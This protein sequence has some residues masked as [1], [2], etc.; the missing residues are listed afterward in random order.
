MGVLDAVV[1]TLR[2]LPHSAARGSARAPFRGRWPWPSPT[3]RRSSGTEGS[4][5]WEQEPYGDSHVDQG[6]EAKLGE[7]AGNRDQREQVAAAHG[8]GEA[9]K[10]D[11]AEH[12]DLHDAGDD[13]KLLGGDGEDEVGVSIGQRVLDHFLAGTATEQPAD[14]E[15]TERGVDLVGVAG[16]G[17]DELVDTTLVVAQVV[18]GH[19]E[20]RRRRRSSQHHQDE[21]HAG[22]EHLHE[23]YG[24][25]RGRHPDIGLQDEEER[26]QDHGDR[27]EQLAVA[28]LLIR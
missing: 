23:P 18:V 20:A 13:A 6:L 4:S 27:Y 10:Y 21:R 17:I 11:E 25:H 14:L 24:G 15:G 5:P 8:T 19:H 7:Q 28:E 3:N 2:I 1:L 26:G 22:H 9:A 16:R 12:S